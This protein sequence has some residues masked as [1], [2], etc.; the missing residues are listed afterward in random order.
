MVHEH[1]GVGRFVGI[2]RDAGGRGGEGLHQDR[3]R[4][5]GL[6]V[7]PRD[8]A[9]PGQQVYRRRRGH[10]SA[11]SSASWG[12]RVG[13]AENRGQEGRQGPGQGPDRS[14]MPSGSSRPGYAF[15]PDYPWQRE[16]EESFR[17]HRRP[18]T[19]CGASRRSRRTWS[20]HGLWTGCYAATWA[21][22]RRR[23]HSG[24]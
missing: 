2:Q 10:T 5:R 16:F 18:T 4:R 3:L 17:L 24:P 7:R 21:T 9:G 8:P 23:W 22:A 19:S 12:R 14:C 1:H 20:S 13:P 11:P 6:P 15:S